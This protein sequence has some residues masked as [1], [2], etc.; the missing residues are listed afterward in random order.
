MTNVNVKPVVLVAPLNWGLGHATRCIPIIHTLQKLHCEPVICANGSSSKLLKSE[1]PNLRHIDLPSYSISYPK[2][3]HKFGIHMLLHL[4]KFFMS[5]LN[6]IQ[7]VRKIANEIKP[8]C[9]ISD[10]RYGFRHKKIFS[11]LVTH[12]VRPVIPRSF[13]LFEKIVHTRLFKLMKH[14]NQIWVPDFENEQ[15]LSGKLSHETGY[16]GKI[17]FCGPLSRFQS[18]EKNILQKQFDLMCIVSGPEP[19]RT[20][21]EEYCLNIA[22]KFNLKICIVAGKPDDLKSYISNNLTYHSH[23]S[24]SEFVELILQSKAILSRAGYSTIMDMFVLEKKSLLVPTPGQTEQKYLAEYLSENGLF[25]QFD[26][27][28]DDLA[29]SIQKLKNQHFAPY[30]VEHSDLSELI[31]NA[32]KSAEKL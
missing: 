13:K 8:V 1:F 24:T 23:P 6:D 30:S 11:I 5:V 15:N 21:F 25:L 17:K 29:S 19:H 18:T 4:P 20:L 14:F 22:E 3:P 2:N 31:K 27:D 12:Q 28:K 9:I 26:P 10:N 32:L 16:K 7:S